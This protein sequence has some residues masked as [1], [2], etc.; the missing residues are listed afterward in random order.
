M[1]GHSENPGVILVL[2]PAG[3]APCWWLPKTF[4]HF[5]PLDYSLEMIIHVWLHWCSVFSVPVGV[6]GPPS[7]PLIAQNGGAYQPGW[8]SGGHR[9]R[10]FQPPCQQVVPDIIV[11][12]TYITR[13]LYVRSVDEGDVNHVTPVSRNVVHASDS[14]EGA[15]R[16]LQLWFQGQ[17]LLNWE[18][19]DELITCEDAGK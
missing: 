12:T 6:G 18:C 1:R 7:D 19:I 14:P 8:S 2:E 13:G 15:L 4:P 3:S 10:R 9:E 17:E 11:F 5:P 16:E